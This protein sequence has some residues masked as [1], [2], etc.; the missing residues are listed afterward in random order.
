[1]RRRVTLRT[2]NRAPRRRPLRF[3]HLESRQMLST[4]PAGF[5]EELVADGLY[6]P[7]AMVVAPDGRIFVTEKPFGVRIVENGQLLATPFITLPVERG[8][9][10]GMAG[11]ALDPNFASNGH[12]YIYYTRREA[13]GSFDRLSR[14]TVSSTDRN[15][16]DP[17]SERVLIDNIPTTEP[18][19]HNGGVLEFGADGM[20]YFGIGDTTNTSLPQDLSKIQGKVLRLN[21]AAW[22]NII[23]TDNP[24]VNISG[25]RGEIWALGFRNPFTG[26]MLPGTSRLFVN[27]VGGGLFEEVNE[28]ARGANYGWP[29][30]E[31]PSTNPQFTNPV[32]AYPHNG[33][34]SAIAGGEFYTGSQFPAAYAGKY[35]YADYVQGFIRT[36]DTSTRTSADF[37]TNVFIP[38]DV[39]TA[40]DGGLYYLSL[41]PGSDTTGAIYK[42]NYVVGNRQPTAVATATPSEGL[43]PLAVTFDGSA[44]SDPDGDLL[45]F[46]WDFGD[47]MTG[48][49]AT[50]THEYA[51]EGRYTARLTVSDGEA[52]VQSQP[53]TIVVGNEAPVGQILTPVAGATYR[54]GS[55]ITFS[56]TASDPQEGQL[57]AS[58]FHWSVAFHH[59]THTH[60]F[61]DAIDDIKSGS[62]VIPLTGEN[63]PNQW[64]RVHLTVTDSTGLAH[65]SFV[66]VHPQTT[67]LSFATTPASGSILLDGSPVATPATITAIVGMQRALEAPAMQLIGGRMYR[68]VNWA[69]GGPSR[70][71]IT[72]PISP[73]AFTANYQTMPLAA[74]YV[75]GPPTNVI[76]GQSLTYSVT[77]TNVG[78]ETWRAT[79]SNRVRLGVYFG[80]ESD[81]VGAWSSTPVR[82]SLSRNIA[83]G[84][85]F[86][87]QVTIA[88]PTTPGPYVLRHR[89]IKEP[90]GWFETM[91]RTNVAVQTLVAGY[92]GSV[93]TLWGAGHSHRY[94]LTVTN[95]GTMTW[96]AAGA[97]PVRLGVYFGG[98]SDTPGTGASEPAR[99]NLPR[100]VAPGE[101]VALS[102]E[103]PAP[104]TAG[105]FTL[106][107]RMIKEGVK[108][109][110]SILRTSVTVETLSATYTAAP[111]TTWAMHQL[112]TY[113]ITVRNAGTTKWP[114]T[115]LNAVRL[116]IYFGGASDVPGAWAAEPQRFDLPGDV[117]PGASVTLN[118]AVRAPDQGGSYTLRHRMVKEGIGWFIPMLKTS[119]AVQTLAATYSGVVPT[120]WL[121]GEEKTWTMKVTNTGTSTWTPT[122]TNQVNL[123]VY[124]AGTSDA[125][126]D[127]PT[128]PIRIA[129]PAGVTS[130]LPGQ[131]VTFTV[132]M[133]APATAGTYVLRHRMVKEYVA[134]FD[135]LLKT[136]VVV[137]MP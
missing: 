131:P 35:F 65:A 9:E 79:G 137:A 102:V 123:G 115:G 108:W 62:F 84:K 82:F 67:T 49:G 22:P 8:G 101:S 126:G 85:S 105:N 95:T 11:L 33:D 51:T 120:S 134:W 52:T 81:A 32:F 103:L 66:D 121:P 34:G 29:L 117:L 75:G 104:T 112:Q 100:D 3:E 39:D 16:A 48:S 17:A 40:P 14:F 28:V 91:Q 106:R 24:Y 135:D 20:L 54:G 10:R 44:S 132:R 2:T 77:I 92:A 15:V 58:A 80:G 87:F 42:I 7:T 59:N 5:Q 47:G 63:D 130:V 53:L 116:G 50:I 27:D 57:A 78:T 26:D 12:V 96:N 18:G 107:H 6:E 23:P 88:A 86:T 68:F 71:T 60:P 61:I 4:L 31:G 90:T 64:Y 99:V 127:W 41:G 37:A 129:W 119:V 74:T 125:V 113:N 30:A 43:A 70:Q 38:V 83:P 136:N 128:E 72:V 76:P 19:W 69:N 45:T 124:F 122:G 94:T 36:L 98:S 109:F 93:P 46:A 55:T 118:V 56:G 21:P 25:A 89:M 110:D 133:R 13:T 111:P 97:N 1:M 73:A 114:A